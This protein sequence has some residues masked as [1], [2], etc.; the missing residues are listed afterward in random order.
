MK[1]LWWLAAFLGQHNHYVGR[2]YDYQPVY[3]TGAAIVSLAPVPK[4]AGTLEYDEEDVETF[5]G[6]RDV[7]AAAPG[8][9]AAVAAP[10]PDIIRTEAA[11]RPV[12][13]YPH[14]RRVG[15]LVFLSGVGP[16]RPGT[17][18]IPGGPVRDAQGRPLDYDA[19]AQ[20]RS[21]IENVKTILEAAGSALDKIIDVTV[22]LV[23]MKRDFAAFN[24]VYKEYFEG[25][26]ATRTTLEIGALP[27]PIAVEFKV[28]AAAE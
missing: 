1:A 9:P 18:E 21:V 15:N 2:V 17:D 23:D 24:A 22:F 8:A 16:R 3:G 6:D 28:L 14:A 12:G 20:T 27:T 26:Q 4:A 25:I 11:P 13:A 10:A 5:R 19:A 7:L